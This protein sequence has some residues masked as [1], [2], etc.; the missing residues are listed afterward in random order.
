MI[1]PTK[2]TNMAQSLLGLGSYVLKQLESPASVDALWHK[3]QADYRD[4]R[5]LAKQSFDNLLLTLIF[6]YSI[7]AIDEQEGVIRKCN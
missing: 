3:Y 7:E 2:H 4:G 5:Y 1:L 6:L